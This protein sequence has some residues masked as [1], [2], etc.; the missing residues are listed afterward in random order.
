MSIYLRKWLYHRMQCEA[1]EVDAS[2]VMQ[3]II[4]LQQ[5]KWCQSHQFITNLQSSE[6]IALLGHLWVYDINFD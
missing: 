2:Q 1:S 4:Q 3:D 5:L 6:H